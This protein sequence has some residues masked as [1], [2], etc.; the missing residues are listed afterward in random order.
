MKS[1]A[2]EIAQLTGGLSV[3]STWLAPF[4]TPMGV[5]GL[6]VDECSTLGETVSER[7]SGHDMEN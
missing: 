2:I 7:Q 1:N 5:I 4:L 3:R 6:A